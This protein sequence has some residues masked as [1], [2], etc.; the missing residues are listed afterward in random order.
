MSLL[1]KILGNAPVI[2]LLELALGFTP[3]LDLP[4][5]DALGHGGHVAELFAL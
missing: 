2:L 3:H 5:L 1:Q 4:P